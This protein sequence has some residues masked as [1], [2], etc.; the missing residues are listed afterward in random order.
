MKGFKKRTEK[1]L[2]PTSGFEKQNQKH[3][4]QRGLCRQTKHATKSTGGQE[5]GLEKQQENTRGQGEGA[6]RETKRKNTQQKHLR[7]RG[8]VRETNRKTHATK[9]KEGIV[10]RKEKRLRSRACPP[11]LYPLHSSPLHLH[12]PHRSSS[13]PASP[14][15]SSLPAPSFPLDDAFPSAAES[16]LAYRLPTCSHLCPK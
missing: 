4:R 15:L 13:L 8:R 16:P 7:S 9:I 10:K 12:P 1:H 3:M 6:G 14:H 2:R 5:N 11:L